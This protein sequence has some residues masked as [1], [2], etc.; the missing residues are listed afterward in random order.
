MNCKECGNV[1]VDNELFCSACGAKQDMA[2]VYCTKCGAGM[3]KNTKFC[4]DC[5][6]STD[7]EQKEKEI[8]CW[9]CGKK[10]PASKKFCPEC[11]A[12]QN[13][14]PG[15]GEIMGQ[16]KTTLSNQGE[17]ISNAAGSLTQKSI[18]SLASILSSVV[19][20]ILLF[21]KWIEVPALGY[22]GYGSSVSIFKVYSWASDL[23]ASFYMDK[24]LVFFLLALLILLCIG[25]IIAYALNTYYIA[26]Q[27]EKA[28]GSGNTATV[29][30]IVL[31]VFV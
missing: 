10:I 16:I 18:F 15:T 8:F 28:V 7:P 19:C 27:S 9:S 6:T 20:I 25:C 5:G 1:L 22:F 24:D 2:L 31:F 29:L 17:N 11:G 21:S 3:P 23:Y 12:K 26:T 13:S 14:S 30:I 4:P